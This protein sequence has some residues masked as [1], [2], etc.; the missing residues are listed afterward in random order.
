M[1]PISA[2]VVN[3]INLAGP[4]IVESDHLRQFRNDHSEMYSAEDREMYRE[5]LV[6]LEKDQ[7]PASTTSTLKRGAPAP[8]AT[9]SSAERMRDTQQKFNRLA[10]NIEEARAMYKAFL[11][12]DPHNIFNLLDK[13]LKR[14]YNICSG[15]HGAHKQVTSIRELKFEYLK[16]KRL[17]LRSRKHQLQCD[18][19]TY[20]EHI[21]LN[22]HGA[23]CVI[24]LSSQGVAKTMQCAEFNTYLHPD[25]ETEDAGETKEDASKRLDIPINHLQTS[26]LCH[27]GIC[28]NPDHVVF[29]HYADNNLRKRCHLFGRCVCNLEPPCIMGCHPADLL[30]LVLRFIG[31]SLP[32]MKNGN[33]SKRNAKRRKCTSD[34]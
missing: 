34:E 8:R 2:A 5:M 30:D 1:E 27:L 21:K 15:Y 6:S 31:K 4:N 28:A 9:R 25:C 32:S 14:M 33:G 17:L 18:C 20:L 12:S 24:T 3:E 19:Y 11:S 10:R 29:E 16:T 22:N 26:H 7:A 13:K 23:C